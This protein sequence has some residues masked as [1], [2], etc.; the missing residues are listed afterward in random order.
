MP[1]TPKH[2]FAQSISQ[3][4]YKG[5]LASEEGVSMAEYALLMAFITLVGL[6]AATILG[7]RISSFFVS[8]STTI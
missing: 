6:A 8:V 3:R 5:L 1:R 2:S 7:S 4:L